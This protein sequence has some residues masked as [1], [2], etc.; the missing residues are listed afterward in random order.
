MSNSTTL[1]TS[2]YDIGRDHLSGQEAYRPFTKYLG[3]FKNMLKINAPM[4]CFI[5]STLESYV[6]EHRPQNYATTIIIRKFTDLSAYK[7]HDRIQTCI[8]NMHAQYEDPKTKPVYYNLCP[9]F[10]TAKYQ[11]IL[12]SKFDFLK[13]VAKSN[14]YN[15][16]YFI[17]L[18]AGIYYNLPPFNYEVP[19]PDPYKIKILGNKFLI[20]NYNLD[21]SDTGPL[22]NIKSFLQSSD[23]RIRGHIFGGNKK[24]INRVHKLVW[25]EVDMALN[26]GVINND[27]PIVHLT[28]LRHP[29]YYY[30]WYNMD[31]NYPNLSSPTN[32]RM[33]PAELAYGMQMGEPYPTNPNIK[34]LTIATLNVNSNKY[35]RWERTAKHFGYNYE[36]LG[37]NQ[38]W[39]GFGTKIKIFYERLK[40][41]VEPYSV[42]TDCTDLFICG[43]ST[44]LLDKFISLNVDLIVGTETF[45]A[46]PNGH[47]DHEKVEAYFNQIKQSSQAFPN[48]GFI[49]GRTHKLLQLLKLHQEHKDDQAA[50]FD[51]IYENKMPLALDYNSVLIG[52]VPNYYKLHYDSCSAFEF[53]NVRG[54]YKL[55]SSSEYPL[56]LHF[57]GGNMNPM[58]KFYL[59]CQQAAFFESSTHTTNTTNW[60]LAWIIFIIIIILIIVIG[61]YLYNNLSY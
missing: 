38:R 54:R 33:I 61:V 55:K 11:V 45:I 43:S 12:F 47:N 57:P 60:I 24:A 56:F 5:D 36:I 10:M 50:C 4:V 51:T 25:N 59:N 49:M 29:E 3:W 18:D 16:E 52:N 42:I 7:Y 37:R 53:D 44:E 35:Q 39:E 58:Q 26:M 41:V 6:K 27:Q 15:S 31:H 17:W 34:L 40:T 48:S 20:S 1:V 32:S 28:I 2:L 21:P 9:E 30:I 8:D 19:W 22:H 14:P 46:Y 23:N 13:E